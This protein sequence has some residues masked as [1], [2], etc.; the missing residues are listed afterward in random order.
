MDHGLRLYGGRCSIYIACRPI[1]VH[2][3]PTSYS[4][5][6]AKITKRNRVGQRLSGWVGQIRCESTRG[7]MSDQIEVFFGIKRKSRTAVCG[8]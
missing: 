5:I 1:A 2:H 7:E 3:T 4:H 6:F 8:G